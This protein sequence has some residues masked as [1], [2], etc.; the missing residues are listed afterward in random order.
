MPVPQRLSV[1]LIVGA[2]VS[3]CEEGAFS[4]SKSEID[5][6][7]QMIL[8]HD[9]VDVD[10]EQYGYNVKSGTGGRTVQL[11]YPLT[12]KGPGFSCALQDGE[13]NS[14]VRIEQ[15]YPPSGTEL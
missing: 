10:G 9:G 14:I 12:E 3:A 15:I 8:E 4:P 13:V 6:C 7:A 1:V 5:A 2:V 11:N